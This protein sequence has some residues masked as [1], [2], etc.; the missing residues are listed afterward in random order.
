MCECNIESCNYSAYN[1]EE[2]KCIL[3]CS[4]VIDDEKY[5]DK[6]NL[7]WK[8]IDKEIDSIYDINIENEKKYKINYKFN[9]VIF[10]KFI[11][12]S[13]FNS[14]HIDLDEDTSIIF[15]KCHFLD[16]TN[17]SKLSEVKDITFDNCTFDEDIF[18]HKIEFKNLFIFEDCTISKNITFQNITFNKTTSFINTKFLGEF[19][20]IH[21]R[22]DDL[23]L[24]NDVDVNTLLLDNTFFNKEANFLKIE[25]TNLDRE[26]ARII[27]YS[28]EKQGNIIESNKFYAKEMEERRKELAITIEDKKEK[29]LKTWKDYFVFKVHGITSNH[30]QDWL[31]SLYWIFI[32]GSTAFFYELYFLIES[33]YNILN[34]AT[35]S[36]FLISPLIINI[37]IENKFGKYSKCYLFLIYSLNHVYIQIFKSDTITTSFSEVINPFQKIT[38]ISLIELIFKV[39]IG[40]LVY[41]F[42]ISIR[43]NTRRK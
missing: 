36:I 13:R 12:T 42:I 14:S 29:S 17:F 22:F 9:E 30:S 4:K 1:S 38:D 31:L 20:L 19:N 41:Q 3:H 40:Y 37:V 21:T 23:A 25:V 5:K 26:T 43:Q 10:P 33:S 27:K 15:T 8:K 11:D 2:D 34:M 35:I 16:V 39:M 6:L 7:F 18:F 24:F 28:F 32:V